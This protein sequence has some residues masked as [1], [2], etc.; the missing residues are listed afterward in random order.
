[1]PQKLP[2]TSKSGIKGV[3][4]VSGAVADR[5]LIEDSF[6]SKRAKSRQ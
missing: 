1:M 2:E 6:I 4:K 5:C 3:L